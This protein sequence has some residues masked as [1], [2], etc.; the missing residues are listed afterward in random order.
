[1]D[2]AKTGS[3]PGCSAQVSNGYSVP[4]LSSGQS[5][6]ISKSV[7]NGSVSGSFSCSFG[8]LSLVSETPVCDPGF[9][10]SGLSCVADVCGSTVPANATSNAIS[11][12]VSGTW[13]YS[14]VAGQCTFACSSG[15]SWDGSSCKTSC[16]V[17]AAETYSGQTYAVS[18][19][20]TLLHGA[21]STAS[22]TA[23][24]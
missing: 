21:A 2:G 5:A 15:F 12:S 10:S 17:P 14:A 19:N 13:H 16:L 6:N 11:Q 24:F 9:V 8:S 7:A 22:A 23:S 20:G 1:M 3:A 4:A 18:P